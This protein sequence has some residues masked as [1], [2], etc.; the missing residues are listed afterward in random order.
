M[1]HRAPHA[2][3]RHLANKRSLPR[4]SLT[5]VSAVARRELYE[6][7]QING[8]DWKRRSSDAAAVVDRTRAGVRRSV[9]ARAAARAAAAAGGNDLRDDRV[10][11]ERDPGQP[12]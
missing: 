4:R 10:H 1:Q 7:K 2:Y 11:P 6:E 9:G 5:R 12:G 3:S 8:D